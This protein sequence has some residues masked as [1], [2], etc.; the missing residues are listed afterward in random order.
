MENIFSYLSE[1]FAVDEG[2][3]GEDGERIYLSEYLAVDDREEET[4]DG[5]DDIEKRDEGEVGLEVEEESDGDGSKET[6]GPGERH[7]EVTSLPGHVAVVLQG[8]DHTDI[9]IDT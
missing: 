2:E 9:L 1:Y 4:R 6:E 8:V 7:G 5:V 3:K